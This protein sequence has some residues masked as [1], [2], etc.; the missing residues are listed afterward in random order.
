[1]K[2]RIIIFL[3]GKIMKHLLFVVL[4]NK[5]E[6]NDLIRELEEEGFNGTVLSS[7]SLKH[8]I[9]DEEEDTLSFVSLA[10]LS[11]EKFVHNTTIYFILEDE[12]LAKV[13]EVI[14]KLTNKFSLIKGGMFAT[15]IE[16]YE[17]SF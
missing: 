16:S 4:E 1:M 9:H 12:K 13:Q 14:R 5:K 2:I 10:H 15:P 3:E 8:V 17:G 7:T 11:E 6:T